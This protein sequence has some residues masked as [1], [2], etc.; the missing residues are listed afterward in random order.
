MQ[1]KSIGR[2]QFRSS[3]QDGDFDIV[4]RATTAGK[5]KPRVYTS[6]EAPVDYTPAHEMA[7][8]RDS[9]LRGTDAET[10]RLFDKL[11]RQQIANKREFVTSATAMSTEIAA[12]IGGS[13]L[14]FSRKAGCPCGC[15][16]GFILDTAHMIDIGNAVHAWIESIFISSVDSVSWGE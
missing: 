5:I 13:K 7:Q 11:R 14:S 4:V 15:S 10:D 12:L 3:F 8:A 9:Y 1:F 6:G 2:S 16:P